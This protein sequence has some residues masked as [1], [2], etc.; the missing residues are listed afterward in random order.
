M[1]MR[2]DQFR[3][4]EANGSLNDRAEVTFT[5]TDRDGKTRATGR[6]TLDM[7]MKPDTLARARERG[8]RV[9]TQVDLPP[10]RYQLRVAA[11]EEGGRAGSVIYDV[12]IPDFYKAPLAMSGLAVTSAGSR[13][14]PTVVPKNPLADFLPAPLITTREFDREDELALFAEF[15][16]NL[17]GAAAH[18]FDITTTVRAEGGRIVTQNTDERSSTE[19]QGTQ[20]GYGY[21]ARIPLNALEPGLYVIRVEG[22][23]RLGDNRENV[24]GRDLQIRVR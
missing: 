2:V 16:E 15:Y 6:H 7:A 14:A 5:A 4:T 17:P 10:G 20:G 3:F 19:L 13:L 11:G 8:L 23:S 21:T 12:E 22:R 9:V 18:K 24:I 1:E